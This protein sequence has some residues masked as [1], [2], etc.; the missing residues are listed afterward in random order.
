MGAAYPFSPPAGRRWRQPVEGQP[1]PSGVE[2]V[3]F[4]RDPASV[5]G[6]RPLACEEP[7]QLK[8]QKPSPRRSRSISLRVPA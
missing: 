8:P 6:A 1:R 5:P 7:K 2:A 4:P 3:G